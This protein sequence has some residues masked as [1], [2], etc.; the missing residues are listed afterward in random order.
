M[1]EPYKA[2]APAP[3]QTLQQ[4]RLKVKVFSPYQTY[5]Q[6]EAISISALNQTGPFDVLGG[7]ANFFSLLVAGQVVV[8]T[9]FT[10]LKFPINHGVIKVT[11]NEITLF[12]DV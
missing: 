10:E 2:P 9:G 6:G 7:H 1:A 12:V 3:K 8:R 4:Q 11:N 5:Y